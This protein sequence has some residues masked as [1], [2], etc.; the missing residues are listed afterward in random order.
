[1]ERTH[2]FAS[3]SGTTTSIWTAKP[4][5]GDLSGDRRG[6]R[7]TGVYYAYSHANTLGGPA[8]EYLHDGDRRLPNALMDAH[9]ML[10]AED[11]FPTG[12]SALT[13]NSCLATPGARRPTHRITITILDRKP[14]ASKGRF[15]DVAGFEVIRSSSR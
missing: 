15:I 10:A 9:D 13:S 5:K 7:R 12:G 8:Q 1:V 2:R 6:S 11:C 3:R 14:A 4:G